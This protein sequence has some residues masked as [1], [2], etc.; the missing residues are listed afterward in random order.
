MFNPGRDVTV[1]TCSGVGHR[2]E[3]SRRPAYI[4]IVRS[5]VQILESGE[6]LGQVIRT[7]G[8]AGIRCHEV[9]YPGGTQLQKHAHESA[10]FGLSMDG[11]YTE[12]AAGTKFYCPPRTAVFHRA[13]EDHT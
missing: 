8:E 7:S 9:F 12:L 2:G 4:N 1:T 5:E 11:V 10:F 3:L 13:Q 6:L